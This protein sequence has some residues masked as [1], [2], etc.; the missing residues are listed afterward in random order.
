M[1]KRGGSKQFKNT[2]DKIFHPFN[3]HATLA[4]MDVW[5]CV[6]LSTLLEVLKNVGSLPKRSAWKVI[7]YHT[8]N[9][10]TT[11]AGTCY[12]G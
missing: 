5:H 2:E 11:V 1:S 6:Q 9:C 10:A 4:Q 8:T 7:A 3:V 12:L